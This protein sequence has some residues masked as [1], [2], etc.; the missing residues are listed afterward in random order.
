M[1]SRFL[2]QFSAEPEATVM[3]FMNGREMTSTPRVILTYD[4]TVTTLTITGVTIE[5]GGEYICKATNS[6]GEASTKTFLRIRSESHI[7]SSCD[8]VMMN[9]LNFC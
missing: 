2:C 8:D 7:A 1:Q 5:D 9:V 3:W 4:K 6:L